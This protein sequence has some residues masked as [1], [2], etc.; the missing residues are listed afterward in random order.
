MLKYSQSRPNER[1]RK[2]AM[3]DYL[4]SG[5]LP[6]HLSTL[7]RTLRHQ[8]EQMA[9]AVDRLFPAG[10]RFSLPPGGMSIWV[11]LPGSIFAGGV[12]RRLA[13][14]HPPHFAG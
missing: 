4:N 2:L 12:P 14:G 1:C 10:C 11:E 9:D 6:R 13:A 5:A 3:T 8:R 7:K